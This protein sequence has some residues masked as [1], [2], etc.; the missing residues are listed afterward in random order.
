MHGVSV[1]VWIVFGVIVFAAIAV[2]L[3][4]VHRKAH[5]VTL[6]QALAETGAWVGL[7]LLFNLWIYVSRGHQAGLEFLTSY[8]VEKSLSVDNIFIFV[9]IFQGLQV[10]P[11]LQHRVLYLG[12]VGAL[13]MRGVFV[14]AGIELLR[15]FSFVVFLFGGILFLTGVRML[16]AG[17]RAVHPEN[18]F[19]VRMLRKVVPVTEGYRGEK[20]LVNESGRW[21]VTPLL[22]ALVA[23]EAMDIVFAVDSVPAVLAITQDVFIAYASNVFA[24]LGL[25][26]M[27]FGLADILPRFRFLHAGLAVLLVFVGAK[28]LAAERISVSTEMSLVVIATIMLVTVCASLI[29]PKKLSP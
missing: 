4:V 19:L 20:F 9:L 17:N 7:A 2:D 8:V 16:L 18:N 22:V 14:F 15:H 26:A 13:A 10:P 27:Y 12:I 3:G 6:R 29:W 23:V 11:K 21:S 5:Q 1:Q 24:I 28:M 25:R